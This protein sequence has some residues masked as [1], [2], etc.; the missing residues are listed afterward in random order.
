MHYHAAF[1]LLRSPVRAPEL[2]V[3]V[4][5]RGFRLVVRPLL[6]LSSSSMAYGSSDGGAT[7]HG[8]GSAFGKA[9]RVAGKVMHLRE[10]KVG[11]DGLVAVCAAGDVE[12]HQGTD[13]RM[14]LLDLARTFPPESCLDTPHLPFQSRSIFFRLL[15]PELL[16]YLRDTGKSP[17]LNPDA[18]CRWGVQDPEFEASC[19][20]VRLATRVLVEE[21]IPEFA[22]W[23]QKDME[24]STRAERQSF[25]FSFHMHRR[26]IG[27]RHL[28]L[29]RSLLP[30]NSQAARQCLLEL[31]ART[32]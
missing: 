12:G 23:L 27:M 29:V 18:F 19:D 21:V 17:P 13:G 5:Y 8:G 6:P 28:G 31:T 14:Y 15:R 10:H 30:A 24:S 20:D 7:F 2:Q 22:T 9:M 4:D 16:L 1:K 26:G 32:L 11:H 25:A 3:L